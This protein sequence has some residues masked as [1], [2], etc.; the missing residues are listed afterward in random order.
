M[1][2]NCFLEKLRDLLLGMLVK[3]DSTG[4]ARILT[5]IGRVHV[6]KSGH[7]EAGWPD[8]NKIKH[9]KADQALAR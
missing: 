4:E 9:T 3:I 2:T 7:P 5:K 8:K 6:K 1:V